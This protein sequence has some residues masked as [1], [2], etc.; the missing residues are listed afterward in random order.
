MSRFWP[1]AVLAIVFGLLG[2]SKRDAQVQ[3]PR[4]VHVDVTAPDQGTNT[5]VVVPPPV[6][7]DSS[8]TKVNASVDV[9]LPPE[10]APP[11]KITYDDAKLG[12]P[13]YPGAVPVANQPAQQPG[14]M[15]YVFET[16][17][18]P[19]VVEQFYRSM[20]GE[21]KGQLSQG[22]GTMTGTSKDFDVKV[23]TSKTKV[24]SQSP[25]GKSSQADGVRIEVE[26]RPRK[27]K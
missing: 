21:P 1:A 16:T 24:A 12:V 26:F 13:T 18:N 5:T 3:P 22:F 10:T 15:T 14:V 23:T 25:D 8:S 6:A 2:C 11:P 27:K 17:D 4:D 7:G 9:Q 19:V 20:I